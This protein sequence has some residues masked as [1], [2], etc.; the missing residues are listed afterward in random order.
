MLS[1]DKRATREPGPRSV[2]ETEP[3]GNRSG[4]AAP[5]ASLVALPRRGGWQRVMAPLDEAGAAGRDP[6]V[7]PDAM[8]TTEEIA[9]RGS[10]LASKGDASAT[11]FRPWYWSYERDGGPPMSDSAGSVTSFPASAPPP[12]GLPDPVSAP[13]IASKPPRRAARPALIAACGALALI[14]GASLFPRLRAVPPT[15]PRP[16]AALATSAQSATPAPAK[17]IAKTEPA[18][19]VTR[20]EM[21]ELMARGNQML[22]TGD[23]AAARL[24]FE[25]AAE[26]GNAAAATAVGKT[27]DPLF[28]ADAH[29]RGLRG[30]PVAA[31]RW[32]RQASA[33]GDGE[34]DGLMKRLMAKYAG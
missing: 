30:D 19:V 34:A 6:T 26:A 27:Y 3:G 5:A 21:A 25:R 28:L 32:Y 7:D 2:K 31:A 24:F 33:G 29:A 15:A 1:S 20:P 14:A 22:A 9:T 16:P 23:I 11:G 12:V 13:A 18:P 10:V 4:G 8:A 17:P